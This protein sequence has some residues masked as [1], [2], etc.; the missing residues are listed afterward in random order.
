MVKLITR[1]FWLSITAALHAAPNYQATLSFDTEAIREISTAAMDDAFLR[2]VCLSRLYFLGSF[3]G[4]SAEERGLGREAAALFAR[5][6]SS[7]GIPSGQERLLAEKLFLLQ[8]LSRESW[9]A[10]AEFGRQAGQVESKLNPA[11][12]GVFVR[13]LMARGK[14][15]TPAFFGGDPKIGLELLAAL[16]G[17]HPA[18][19]LVQLFYA[20]ALMR[21]GS[22]SEARAIAA[23]VLRA[24]PRNDF[25]AYI[26]E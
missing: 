23:D 14:T 6:E 26:A 5:I 11:S 21:S 10:G 19:P 12:T 9:L 8:N 17:Q 16:R 22:R 15:I 2:A 7:G 4:V 20:E 25:A 1:C 3:N 18:D 24:D 13:A